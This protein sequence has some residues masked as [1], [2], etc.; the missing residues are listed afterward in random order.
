MSEPIVR[1]KCH[2]CDGE[3]TQYQQFKKF[4]DGLVA[5]IICWA[6]ETD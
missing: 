3:I 5:H 6:Q 1:P 4:K 2:L